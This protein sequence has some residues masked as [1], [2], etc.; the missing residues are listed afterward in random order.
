MCDYFSHTPRIPSLLIFILT[1]FSHHSFLLFLFSV[2]ECESCPSIAQILGFMF[3]GMFL[4]LGMTIFIITSSLKDVGRVKKSDS[5]Q[6]IILN[7]FQVASFAIAF[8]LRW[9]PFLQGI[10]QFQGSISTLGQSLMNPECM[11]SQGSPAAEFFYAKLTMFAMSPFVVV[12][13]VYLYWQWISYR[14]GVSLFAK[15]LVPATTTIKDKLILTACTVIYLIYP[16]LCVQA[17]QVF[18]CTSVGDHQYLAADLE[19]LC[20]EGRHLLMVFLLGLTQVLLYVI[21]LPSLVFV[22]LRRN[23]VKLRDGSSGLSKHA[24]IVRYG[25]FY[26]A[27]KGESYYWELVIT[28]RKIS[29]IALSVFGP[30]MGTERQTQMVLAVLFICI[31]LEIAGDPYKL[32]DE[33]FRVLGRLEI[34]SLFVQWS[35]MWGGSMIFASQDKESEGFVM[36]LSIVIAVENIAL[37]AW[38]VM[39]FAAAYKSERDAEKARELEEELAANGGINVKRS[40]LLDIVNDKRRWVQSRLSSKATTQKKLRSRTVSS[41]NLT[42]QT[43]VNPLEGIEMSTINKKKIREDRNEDEDHGEGGARVGDTTSAG[44]QPP[45]SAPTRR[46]QQQNQRPESLIAA[47]SSRERLGSD[48]SEMLRKQRVKSL[49]SK[50]K[51]MKYKNPMQKKKSSTGLDTPATM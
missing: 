34:I 14:Q 35:T 24:T 17:F 44:M 21:L 3:L 7:H 47:G 19:E 16:T 27:Y 32:V 26:G 46:N 45:P 8:P 22:L 37:L 43:N 6:K 4:V 9:P 2:A 28:F 15:R 49:N 29:I 50:K 20:W 38:S 48:A 36:F 13:L 39:L 41:K 5:L 1:F 11:L 23:N 33:S 30:A 18:H 31:S 10:F 25:L 40:T 42:N 12:F 51:G